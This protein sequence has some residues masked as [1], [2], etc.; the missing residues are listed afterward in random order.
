MPTEIIALIDEILRKRKITAGIPRR[1]SENLKSLDLNIAQLIELQHLL[2]DLPEQSHSEIQKLYQ[3]NLEELVDRIVQERE[4]W[5]I[6]WQRLNRDT[7]NIGVVGLARQGKSTFLQKVAG[8]T[9]DE[10]P[11]S[12]R[13]PCTSVQS[14][15]YHTEE[16]T[17][18]KVYFH[19]QKSFLEQ[20]ISPYFDELGFSTAP[21]SLIEFRNLALSQPT[22]PRHPARAQA[23]YNHLKDDYKARIGIYEG[24]L[25]AEK[26]FIEVPKEKIREYVSQNYDEKGNPQ[27]F[28]HLAVEKVEIH[29]PFPEM[30]VQ[31]IGLVDMPGLGDT[32]LGD[33]KRMIKALGQDVDFILFIR[34]PD[35]NGDHWGNRDVDLYD[36]ASQAL[37]DKLP[38]RE[39]SFL[40]LNQDGE[41]DQQCNDLENTRIN[42]G[43]HVKQCLRGNCTDQ[44]SANEIL[45]QVLNELA[46]NM[47][48]LDHQYT[49]AAFKGLENL[50]E[51]TYQKLQETKKVA[52]NL[53][54]IDTACFK[55]KDIFIEQLYKEVEDFRDKA[56][57]DF[58][59]PNAEF[60]LQVDIAIDRCKQEVIIPDTDSI[61]ILAKNRG[62]DGAYFDAMQE[63]R[64]DLLQKFHS[65]EAGLKQS[66][67]RT[68]SSL[69]NIFIQL[70][71]GKIID[72]EGSEFLEAFAEA[73][74][75]NNEF[76]NLAMG[77][78][79][80]V[81]FEIMYKG[82]IQSQ[83]WQKLSEV[84]PPDTMTPVKTPDSVTTVL[85]ALQQRRDKAI[86]EC[87]QAL[88][89]LGESINRVQISMIEEFSDHITRA[90]GVKQEWD[91]LLNKHRVQIWS[92]L[93]ELEKQKELQTQWLKSVDEAIS[94]VQRL[95]S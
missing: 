5:Q 61:V 80:I 81:S 44:I 66:L 28:N 15:I 32:R 89:T 20:V 60:K 57:K 21:K 19:S 67:Y 35:K 29:C 74:A 8:L 1:I 22:N 36:E 53:Y 78:N 77:F 16:S 31:K 82:F 42:K 56:R 55:L 45:K 51:S 23:V 48:R 88:N 91:I 64:A 18:A 90:N 54:N 71:L 92:Q 9:N 17:K 86:D 75:Q 83:I 37:K 79:F 63:M 4:T 14:N 7:L 6:L 84:L 33:A 30:R 70:G 62:I 2:Q 69:A 58:K 73:L 87:A 93:Q 40:L 26:R 52:E 49:A 3:L 47:D 39:W 27:F 85:T 72:Q 25:K 95:S 41:N 13:M 94:T 24:E 76:K 68:K 46:E 65:V 12:D 11:S 43:L 10:I 59:Q 50:Q 34:R 38:L